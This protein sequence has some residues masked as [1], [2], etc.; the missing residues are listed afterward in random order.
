MLGVHAFAIAAT[1]TCVVAG[2]WQF[3]AYRLEQAAERADRSGTAP[4]PLREVLSP[5]DGLRG[6]LVGR[7]VV[8]SGEY[9][10]ADQQLLVAGREHDGQDGWWVLSPLLT[11]GDT[12]LLVVRGWTDTQTPPPLPAGRVTVTASL[13]PGEDAS[14]GARTTPEPG[15]PVVDLVRLQSL[16]NVL[17][18]RLYPAYGIRTDET[19]PPAASLQ[20]VSA[21]TPAPSWTT[22]S[23]NLAYALQWWLFAAFTLF[24]WWRVVVDRLRASPAREA[25]APTP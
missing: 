4:V 20:Q 3:D 7:R 9:A 14:N 5:D 25:G 1:L 15:D 19:P 6:D 11:D 8:A 24:M 16:V 13:Q 12:A 2:Y 21:P 10:P 22:G 23:R 17:P 18:Y